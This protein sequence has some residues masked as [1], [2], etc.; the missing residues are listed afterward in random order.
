MS[1]NLL[2]ENLQQAAYEYVQAHTQ[3][4]LQEP[5]DGVDCPAELKQ[6]LDQLL[7]DSLYDGALD[8]LMSAQL[9]RGNQSQAAKVLGINRA[10][11]RGRLF[12]SGLLLQRRQRSEAEQAAF[13]ARGGKPCEAKRQGKLPAKEAA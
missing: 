3:E 9:I 5:L 7:K 11:L 10:T 4:M 12:R 8:A 6:P 13:E 2:R 1:L